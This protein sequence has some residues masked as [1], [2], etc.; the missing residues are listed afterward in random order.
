M[1]LTQRYKGRIRGKLSCPDRVMIT[2]TLVEFGHAE[3]ATRHLKRCNIRIFD[4][5][6]FA[7]SQRDAIRSNAERLAKEAGIELARGEFNI[8]G[9]RGRDLRRHLPGYAGSQMSRVLKR[10]RTHGV[11]KKIG[12]TYK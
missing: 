1:L 7:K 8:S 5:A 11:I 9:F 6:E 12:R 3:A 4:F 2:G 10:L